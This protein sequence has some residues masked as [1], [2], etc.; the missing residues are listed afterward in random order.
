M[1][2][3]LSSMGP[4]GRSL[5]GALLILHP[6]Q[7]EM[8][9]FA[10]NSSIQMLGVDPVNHLMTIPPRKLRRSAEILIPFTI[11]R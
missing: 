7:E 4:R 3:P 9:L 5:S 10:G 2:G 6:I 11:S 1:I 8:H